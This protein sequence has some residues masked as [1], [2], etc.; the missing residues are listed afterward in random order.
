ML[1]VV[2]SCGIG[3]IRGKAIQ[4]I[5]LQDPGSGPAPILRDLTSSSE[6]ETTAPWMAAAI[7]KG[8][9][10]GRG[11]VLIQMPGRR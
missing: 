2:E 11:N 8:L 5:K 9:I 7:T 4:S 6:R 1:D 10:A 3:S